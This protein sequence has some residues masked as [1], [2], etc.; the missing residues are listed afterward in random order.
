MI[1]VNPILHGIKNNLFYVGGGIYV[2]PMIS[3]KKSVLRNSF[4]TPK[5]LPKTGLHTKIQG[6]TSKNKKMAAVLSAN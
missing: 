4:R 2:T 3:Q 6:S 5:Q 1:S